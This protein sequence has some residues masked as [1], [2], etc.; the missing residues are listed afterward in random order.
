MRNL[1]RSLYRCL[2][3]LSVWALSWPV[4]ADHTLNDF[5]TLDEFLAAHPQQVPLSQ[6]FAERVRAPAQ[7]LSLPQPR[8][9]RNNFV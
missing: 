9:I 7:P 1:H 5:W 6:A 4:F 3:L 2:A 8:P